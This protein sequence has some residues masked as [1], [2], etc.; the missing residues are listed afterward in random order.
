VANE[1][2]CLNLATQLGVTATK[3]Q[4]LRVPEP[5]LMVKRFDRELR[6]VQ[7]ARKHVIDACQALGLGVSHK[8]ERNFGS[9]RD[10]AH[11]RD[12]VSLEKVFSISQYAQSSAATQAEQLES[13]AA[14]LPKV[15]ID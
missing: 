2:F 5:V 13:D 7:V 3:A 12:G 4:I 8:Y 11:I 6:D 1:H 9:G 10:V 14:L 15:E